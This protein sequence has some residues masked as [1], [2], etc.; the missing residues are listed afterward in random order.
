MKNSKPSRDQEA[1]AHRKTK[2]FVSLSEIPAL[3]AHEPST[4][5]DLEKRIANY[6]RRFTNGQ[7]VQDREDVVAEATLVA[8]ETLEAMNGSKL[9]AEQQLDQINREIKKAIERHRKQAQRRLPRT[10]S[11]LIPENPKYDE[12]S[13]LLAKDRIRALIYHLIPLMETTLES[14]TPKD[15]N[16]IIRSYGLEE[17]GL[18]VR[19]DEHSFPT[20]DAHKRAVSRA[21]QRF[22]KLLESHLLGAELKKGI[23]DDAI[24]FVRGGDVRKMFQAPQEINNE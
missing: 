19:A 6:A 18:A 24:K 13:Q 16:L 12:V 17:I 22:S 8:I 10:G 7:S 5:A 20:A 15:R 21:R 1:D 2:K 4:L 3:R 11:N 9:P 14:L 23:L